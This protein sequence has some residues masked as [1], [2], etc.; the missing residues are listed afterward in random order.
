[1]K[2]LIS[3]FK[4]KNLLAVFAMLFV[5]FAAFADEKTPDV[6][7]SRA[8]VSVINGHELLQQTWFWVLIVVVAVVFLCAFLSARTKDQ[9]EPHAL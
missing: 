3:T 9:K 2:K 7:L 8:P 1:M 6:Y 5:Q 4:T